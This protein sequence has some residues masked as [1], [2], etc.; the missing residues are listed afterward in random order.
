MVTKCS[1]M[2]AQGIPWAPRDIPWPP[3]EPIGLLDGI[4]DDFRVPFGVHLGGMW[5]TFLV[6]NV[7][8][9]IPRIRDRFSLIFWSLLEG[10]VAPKYSK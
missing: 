8:K 9:T 4:L 5:E 1:Q 6:K 3:Q 7:S 10:P 2:R